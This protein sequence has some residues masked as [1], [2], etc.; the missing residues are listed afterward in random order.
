MKKSSV[1]KS[2]I[3]VIIITIISKLIGALRD[4]LI[5]YKFGASYQTDA[6]KLAISIPDVIF[7]IIGLAIS[8][9][10]IPML[11]EVRAK[12]GKDKMNEFASK[13][14]N[15][16]TVIAVV[17]FIVG[18]MFPEKI[19]GLIAS[20]NMDSITLATTVKLTKI[21]L[22]NI[23]FLVVNACFV[24]ILQVNEDFIVP[25]ILGLFFN[26]PMILYMLIV[27]E[28]SIY[29]LTIANVLGNIF[30]IFVQIPS[31]KRN[32]FKYS[33]LFDL[34]DD[35]IKRFVFIIIPV[36][37]SAS[38]NSLNLIIDK[39][40]ASSLGNG[41]ITT[42]DNAQ[43]LVNVLTNLALT[44]IS[45]VIYPVLV[46][47]LNEKKQKS[48][49]ELI[50]K[51]LV[52]LGILLIPISF[53]AIVYGKEIIEVVYLRG[54]YTLEATKFTILA[55]VGYSIG[56]FFIGVKDLLNSSF[57]SMGKTKITAKISVIGVIINIILSILLSKFIGIMGIAI[58]SSVS[59]IITS[60]LLSIYIKKEYEYINFKNIGYDIVKIIIA[61]IIMI[62]TLVP[63]K[64]FLKQYNNFIILIISV[65]LGGIVYIITIVLF[66]VNGI[67]ELVELIRRRRK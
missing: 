62:I 18:I 33:F 50:N 34:Q 60:I 29:G 42:L 45:S 14:I 51:T 25:T 24:A 37:I 48:F 58:A 13:I 30:R 63:L 26:L 11:S 16:L 44:A 7:T 19:V 61:S 1:A 39:K 65:V 15:I 54:E 64:N 59:M 49:G 6:Y 35:R 2:A 55:F 20:K 3:I 66:K 38:A 40:I 47:Q 22:I 4:V 41:V 28:Y 10:F 17:I 9:A 32:G 57:F 56:I 12:E 53:G 67:K 36:I 43:L 46:N 23:V 52:Y 31:L 27:K 5:S 8:T 21:I